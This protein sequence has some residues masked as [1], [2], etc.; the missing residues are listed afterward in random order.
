MRKSTDCYI[1]INFSQN[2]KFVKPFFKLG[3]GVIKPS[4]PTKKMS[5][6]LLQHTVKFERVLKQRNQVMAYN[7][8][9][10]QTSAFPNLLRFKISAVVQ[11]RAFNLEDQAF[12]LHL[13]LVTLV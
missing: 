8:T 13:R 12:D 5:L 1:N 3:P 7:V 11:L 2:A 6:K 9:G 4:Y 10:P